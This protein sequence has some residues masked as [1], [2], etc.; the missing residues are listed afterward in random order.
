MLDRPTFQRFALRTS[1]KMDDISSM[2]YFCPTLTKAVK[3]MKKWEK[4]MLTVKPQYALLKDGEGYE[5][6]NDG[7][8]VQVKIIGKLPNGTIFVKKAYDEEPFEFKIEEQL[9]I[10]GVLPRVYDLHSCGPKVR[11]LDLPCL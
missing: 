3:T 6:P 11:R 2:D 8:L 7:T 9:M 1:K 5:R 4:V 10:W